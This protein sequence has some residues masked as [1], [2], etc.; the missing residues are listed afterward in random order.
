MAETAREFFERL[1]KNPDVPLL[2]GIKGT[3]RFDVEDVGSWR[4][5]VDDGAIWVRDGMGEADC[6]VGS[7]EHDFLSIASGE[8]NLLT[9]LLRGEI[10]FEG[11][12]GLL[13]AFHGMLPPP[14]AA[15]AESRA[16]A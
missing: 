3:Y 2:K 13:K 9:A 8:M 11:D 15:A 16:A 7:T 4:V 1:R 6:I 12:R 10:H 5:T 14:P